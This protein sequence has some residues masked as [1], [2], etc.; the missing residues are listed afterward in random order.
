M[1]KVL[2]PLIFLQDPENA[3]DRILKVGEY[4]GRSPLREAVGWLYDF[5]DSRL[6]SDVCGIH[7][8]NPVGMAAGFDKNGVLLDF[9]PYLGFGYAEIGSVTAQSSEGNPKTRLFRLPEDEAIINR[10]GLNGGGADEVA[11]RL[12]N[13]KFKIPVG[14]NIA[15]TNYPSLQDDAAIEDYCYSFEKLYGI[16]DY[17][18]INISCPNTEDGRTFED[19]HSLRE[20]LYGLRT[21]ERELIENGC[22][23]KPVL[24]KISP[25][26][27]YSTLDG[28][29]EVSEH[30]T[31]GYVMCNT[32][33]GRFGLRTS[34]K[35]IAEIGRGGLSGKP[36]RGKSTE[37]IGYT[38]RHL[39]R[40]V[41]IGA[42]G[43]DSPEA[44]YEK[45]R[46]GASLVQVFTGLV[47]E[48]PALV[49]KINQGLVKLLER[50]GFSSIPEA[51]G[52]P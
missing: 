9:L 32:S 38:Y 26:L 10:M 29:L 11:G 13:R 27:S 30:F 49:K 18:V 40:P 48:G 1:Y 20:L 12:A 47:Y 16:A 14:I 22:E 34:K 43:I 6:E 2:R 21:V 46:A 15:K 50:D 52:A 39:E 4:L 25:D 5:K 23:K 35:R 19:L 45:I 51:V 44:A 28:I 8:L 37:L 24:I 17:I 42:G 31:A 33:S 3:H 36:V 41:I 7:F